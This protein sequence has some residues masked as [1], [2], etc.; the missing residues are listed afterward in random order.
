M[1]DVKRLNFSCFFCACFIR[2]F[3]VL[4]PYN[5]K[6][7]VFSTKKSTSLKWREKSYRL[8]GGNIGFVGSGM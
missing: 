4:H 7:M 1:C 3:Y 6:Q 2:N 5:Q 8:L